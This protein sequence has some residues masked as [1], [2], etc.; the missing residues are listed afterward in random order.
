MAEL[1][2]AVVPEPAELPLADWNVAPTKTVAAVLNR[3]LKGGDDRQP[4]RQ[5][6]ALRWGLVP[7]FADSP[8]AAVKMINARAETLHEKPAYRRAFASR[9]CL[10]PAD[11]YYEW[12]T[13]EGPAAKKRG[14]KQAYF[15]TPR[16]GSPVALAGIFEFWRDRTRPEG[17][18]L[19]WWATCA[20]VTT[21]AEP[22]LAG[23][24]PRMP[25]ILPSDRWADWLDPAVDTAEEAR[26]LLVPPPPGQLE[27][28]PIGPAVGSVRNNG[29]ELLEPYEPVGTL[30]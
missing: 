2:E 4:V 6:R 12:F 21:E 30:F 27:P 26:S 9:R 16:D 18:P 8:A 19:A 22:E 17:D 14:P 5:L 23:I 15:I 13:P 20:V 25:L 28:R 7:S 11:G 3:P 10:L 1:F 24:H 29:P